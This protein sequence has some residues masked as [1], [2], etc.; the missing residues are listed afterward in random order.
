MHWTSCSGLQGFPLNVTCTNLSSTSIQCS[1]GITCQNPSNFTSIFSFYQSNL[2][3][4]QTQNITT[5]GKNYI[6]TNQGTPNST[7]VTQT[8]SGSTLF[9]SPR[10]WPH[11]FLLI[12]VFCMMAAQVSAISFQNIFGEFTSGSLGTYLDNHLNGKPYSSGTFLQDI[13][14]ATCEGGVVGGALNLLGGPTKQ[15]VAVLEG[16]T[17][18]TVPEAELHLHFSAPCCATKSS[19]ASWMV[20]RDR[21]K[22][23][24][25]PCICWRISS[26]YHIRSQR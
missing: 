13:V 4:S 7:T 22:M 9:S 5:G 2:T 1:N 24:R 18:I 11:L 12:I 10:P 25:P 21:L 8:S 19:M 17:V 3:T 20:F 6:L 14:G 23:Y 16:L 26:K 15:C